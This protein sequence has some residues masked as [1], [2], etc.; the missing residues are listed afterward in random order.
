MENSLSTTLT[1]PT[2]PFVHFCKNTDPDV[3]AGVIRRDCPGTKI[4]EIDGKWIRDLKQMV[5]VLNRGL[6][7]SLPYG[8][9]GGGELFWMRFDDLIATD[10]KFDDSEG[11]VIIV[12]NAEHALSATSDGLQRFGNSMQKAGA[13]YAN[14]MRYIQVDSP[15]HAIQPKLVHTVLCYRKTPRNAPHANQIKLEA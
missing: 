5:D 15:D 13:G 10:I 3:V 4:V 7:L 2:A 9:N 12:G 14:P 1:S 11:C 8:R 6:G